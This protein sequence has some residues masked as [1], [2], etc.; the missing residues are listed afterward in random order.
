MKA[1]VVLALVAATASAEPLPPGSIGLV[2]GGNS[3]TGADAKKLGAGYS[4][5]LQAA[6]QPMNTDRRVGWAIRWGTFFGNYNLYSGS[7][8]RIDSSIRT[9]Q[10]DFTAGLRFRPWDA[11][12]SYITLRGGAEFFR[13][14]EP[15]EPSTM[16]RSFVGGITEVGYEHFGGWYLLDVDVRYGLFGSQPSNVALLVGFSLVGP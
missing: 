13:A 11:P 7:A 1:L 6:W 2:A 8:A 5:G 16:Q 14:N 3:G 15:I 12:A 9:V 4:F 10:M